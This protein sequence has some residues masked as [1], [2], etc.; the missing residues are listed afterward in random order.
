MK[1]KIILEVDTDLE[2]NE[3]RLWL[4]QLDTKVQTINERTKMHTKDIQELRRELKKLK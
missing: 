2:D 3:A 1:N 4:K